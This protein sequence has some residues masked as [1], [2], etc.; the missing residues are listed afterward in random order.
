MLLGRK[1]PALPF[2]LS[3]GILTGVAGLAGVL[4]RTALLVMS[5]HWVG[6]GLGSYG[7]ARDL[8]ASAAISLP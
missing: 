1:R 6:W 8:F 3:H 7:P 2:V 5:C 4:A